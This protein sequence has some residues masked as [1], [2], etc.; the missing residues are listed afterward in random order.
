M[1]RRIDKP[2]PMPWVRWVVFQPNGSPVGWAMGIN[3]D[4][5]IQQW[6][7]GH[8]ERWPASEQQGYTVR[9][10]QL[11]PYIQSEAAHDQ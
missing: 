1:P 5:A 4:V 11:T 9:P 3:R 10:V 8:P 7:D 6:T 2:E